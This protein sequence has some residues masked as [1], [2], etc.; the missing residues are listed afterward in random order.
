MSSFKAIAN[1]GNHMV[2]TEPRAYS[3]SQQIAEHLKSRKAVVINL[4]E[5]LLSKQKELLTL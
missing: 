4:K 3:E 1:Q 2:L 5:L